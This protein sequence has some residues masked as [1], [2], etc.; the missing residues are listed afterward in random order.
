MSKGP[1]RHQAASMASWGRVRAPGWGSQGKLLG[2]QEKAH[3]IYSLPAVRHDT[4]DSTRMGDAMSFSQ[5]PW[6]SG[7][8]VSMSIAEYSEALRH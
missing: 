7:A 2:R 8:A 1:G 4:P 3:H 5:Q 6:K